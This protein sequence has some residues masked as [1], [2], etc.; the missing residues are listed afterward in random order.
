MPA[1]PTRRRVSLTP[2]PGSHFDRV[3]SYLE[4]KN[5]P[6]ST[7]IEELL[8]PAHCVDALRESG[9]PE[10][11]IQKHGVKHIGALEAL[12]KSLKVSLGYDPYPQTLAVSTKTAGTHA[13]QPVEPVTKES[14]PDESATPDPDDSYERASKKASLM[15][16]E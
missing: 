2:K 5:E 10:R 6:L 4:E 9:T 14:E 1:Q 8:V 16:K 7:F 15:F 3:L 12:A 13:T 11:E